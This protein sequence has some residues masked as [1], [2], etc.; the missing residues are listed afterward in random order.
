MVK[1]NQD[2]IGAQRVRNDDGVLAVSDEN[3][4]EKLLWRPFHM[5]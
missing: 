3:S 2:I 5:G 4:L 1:T